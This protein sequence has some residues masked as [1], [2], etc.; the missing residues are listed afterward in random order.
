MR[1]GASSRHFGKKH[2]LPKLCSDNPITLQST[3]VIYRFGVKID[4]AS[5]DSRDTSTTLLGLDSH[6]QHLP[7]PVIADRSRDGLHYSEISIPSDFPPGSI[8]VFETVLEGM[9]E[10]IDTTCISGAAEAVC[11][12][13]AA[14]INCLLFRAEGEEQDLSK[15]GSSTFGL[16]L[17]DMWYLKRLATDRTACLAWLRSFT[18]GCKDGYRHCIIS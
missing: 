15:S 16:T 17:P 10:D 13:T 7:E 12:L 11:N 9:P 4:I 3:Q 8:L 6:L 5:K 14:E 18:A 2:C 1:F